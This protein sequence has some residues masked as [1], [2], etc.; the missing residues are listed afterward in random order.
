[1]LVDWREVP[2]DV[3]GLAPGKLRS[4]SASIASQSDAG[5]G[6]PVTRRAKHRGNP[7]AEIAAALSAVLTAN[8]G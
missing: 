6:M 3:R 7:A 2:E 5:R 4:I 8:H 1:M